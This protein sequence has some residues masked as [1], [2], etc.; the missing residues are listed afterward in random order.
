MVTA[1]PS[2]TTAARDAKKK[3]KKMVGRVWGGEINRLQLL[4]IGFG[5]V[6]CLLR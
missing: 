2:V 4:E 6:E 5:A 3:K 1:Q